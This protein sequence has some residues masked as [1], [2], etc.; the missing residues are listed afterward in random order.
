MILYER[1]LKGSLIAICLF[2]IMSILQLAICISAHRPVAFIVMFSFLIGVFSILAFVILYDMIQKDPGI[3]RCKVMFTEEYRIH[4][5]KPNGKILKLRV[6][7]EQYKQYQVDQ[8]LELLIAKR[9]DALLAIYKV[10]EAEKVSE[11]IHL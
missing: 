7:A 11:E 1:S 4:I 8:T 3:V 9:S 6:S 5:Q 2:L 10:E